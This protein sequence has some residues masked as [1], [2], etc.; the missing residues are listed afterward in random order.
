[1]DSQ[2]QVQTDADR[3]IFETMKRQQ[4]LTEILT[5]SQL[6][7][8]GTMKGDTIEA[9][10]PDFYPQ[11]LRRQVLTT[12]QRSIAKHEGVRKDAAGIK[13]DT[14]RRLKEVRQIARGVHRQA[15]ESEVC[16]CEV[17][18]LSAQ[19]ITRKQ[20]VPGGTGLR[21]LPGGDWQ[22]TGSAGR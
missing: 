14:Q 16:Q 13:K 22:I 21:L 5:K 20:L 4:Q 2:Q 12:S 18:L 19:E 11:F 17:L 10:R 9:K 1:M 8:L 7:I 6:D 15:R 3:E